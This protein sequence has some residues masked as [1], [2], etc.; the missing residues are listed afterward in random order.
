M[1]KK[2]RK[3]IIDMSFISVVFLSIMVV[4]AIGI[5]APFLRKGDK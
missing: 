1:T 3:V 5:L 2:T 4:A